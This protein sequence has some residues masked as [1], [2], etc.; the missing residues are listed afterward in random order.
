VT[1]TATPPDVNSKDAAT[2]GAFLMFTNH[3]GLGDARAH[4]LTFGGYDSV[5]GTGTFE[6]AT[7]VRVWGP[8][9]LRAGAVYTNG[10][11]TLRPSVGG[12]VQALREGRHGVD[13]AAGM[14]YRP[15]GLSEPEGEVESVVSAGKH[16]GSF[17]ALGNLLYGQDPEGNERDGEVR[18]AVLRPTGARFLVG[19]DGRLRFDLGS[20]PATLAAHNEPTFDA[21]VGPLFGARLG[22]I[23]LT[24]QGGAA[25]LRRQQATSYGAFAVLGVGTA[26]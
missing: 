8:M 26:L 15:E 25:A 22:P 19:V 4:A 23:M 1:D 2:Q 7:E 13:L 6:A 14:F 12:R 9:S 16:L 5:R 18:L 10:N 11:R 3:A 24:A 21:N 20:N 17:Y